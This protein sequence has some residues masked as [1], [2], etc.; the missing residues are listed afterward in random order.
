MNIWLD[1]EACVFLGGAGPQTPGVRGEPPGKEHVEVRE[2]VDGI[3]MIW[4]N[5]S[6]IR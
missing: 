4:L 5:G 2:M 3:Q 1:V 6:W